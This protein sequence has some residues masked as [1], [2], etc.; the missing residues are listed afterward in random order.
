MKG[1]VILADGFEDT[2][3]IATI[4]VLKRRYAAP[5]TCWGPSSTGIWSPSATTC[6][7]GSSMRPSGN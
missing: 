1:L 5:E 3:A 6:T 2:E 7:A 4:D